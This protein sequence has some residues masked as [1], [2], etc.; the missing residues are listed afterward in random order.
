MNLAVH[1]EDVPSLTERIPFD[2]PD[3]GRD[4]GGMA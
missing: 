1:M 2:R 3:A 4:G